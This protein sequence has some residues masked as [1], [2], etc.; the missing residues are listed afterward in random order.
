MDHGD[1]A[2]FLSIMQATII[3]PN[4][5]IWYNE[6]MDSNQIQQ[7]AWE[8]AVIYK[9]TVELYQSY[10]QTLEVAIQK[11]PDSEVARLTELNELVQEA[12]EAMEHDLAIFDKAVSMDM[13]ALAGMQDELKIQAIYN[14]LKK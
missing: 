4:H 6:V 2:I 11:T 13:E 7:T 9:A 3:D 1:F 12:K 5:K 10:F 8:L 14:K